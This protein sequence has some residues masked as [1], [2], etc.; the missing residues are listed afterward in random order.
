MCCICGGNNLESNT[1]EVRTHIHCSNQNNIQPPQI[2]DL[3]TGQNA[4]PQI[5]TQKQKQLSFFKKQHKKLLQRVKMENSDIESTT[6][7]IMPDMLTELLQGMENLSQQIQ[8]LMKL[9]ASQHS[10]PDRTSSQTEDEA[11]QTHLPKSD[12]PMIPVGIISNLDLRQES[13]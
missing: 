9:K 11:G 1:R 4:Q 10:R 5:K 3:P 7:T 13:E 2:G 6:E 12:A 8:D